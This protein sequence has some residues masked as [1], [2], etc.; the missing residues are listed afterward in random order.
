MRAA[1]SGDI[2]M[3]RSILLG[4][5]AI[6][7]LGHAVCLHAQDATSNS[8]ALSVRSYASIQEAIDRNPA[9]ILHLPAGDHEITQRIRLTQ[10]GSGLVGP[11]RIIQTNP[12]EPIID[13]RDARD[14]ELRG[15][16]LTRSQAR[17]NTF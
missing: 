16:T 9:R 6:A 12:A 17:Q 2:A 15:L 3:Q 7:G 11:G 8:D 13:V 5:V 1:K 10:N 4:I 14:V